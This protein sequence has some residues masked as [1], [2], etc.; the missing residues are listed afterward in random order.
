MGN[1]VW[2]VTGASR[3]I[4]AEIA[5][6]VLASGDTLVAA[7]RT[8]SAAADAVAA[9][10]ERFGHIDIVVNNAGM[11]LGTDCLQRIAEKDATVHR[12]RESWRALAAFTDV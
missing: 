10:I 2:L 3:G 11:P 4:G 7:A 12:E 5:K 6:A 8:A 1:R 9:G